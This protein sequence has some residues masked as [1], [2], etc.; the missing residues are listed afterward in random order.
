M[1]IA[2]LR[3]ELQSC[4]FIYRNMNEALFPEKKSN[5]MTAAAARFP[6]ALQMRTE[7]ARNGRGSIL[8]R[9]TTYI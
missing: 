5:G 2:K 3:R 9:E 1:N 4:A 8:T 7:K 6:L